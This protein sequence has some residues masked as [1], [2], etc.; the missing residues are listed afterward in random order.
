[1]A[2]TKRGQKGPGWEL[3]SRRPGIK[4]GPPGRYAKKVT[5]RAERRISKNEI[6]KELKEKED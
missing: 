3:W 1:M 4:Y 5:L 6:H 2:R